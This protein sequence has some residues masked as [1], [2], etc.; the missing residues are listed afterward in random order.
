LTPWKDSSRADRAPTISHG[1]SSISISLP[2]GTQTAGLTGTG[3]KGCYRTAKKIDFTGYNS[4]KFDFGTVA[5][6]GAVMVGCIDKLDVALSGNAAAQTTV[7]A[8]SGGTK[9]M[10]ISALNG[11]YYIAITMC[12]Y[13]NST[14]GTSAN[15][16]KVYL[17]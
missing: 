13:A 1:T 4:L 16:K 6:G 14:S 10:D 2:A 9:A 7:A 5:V 3:Y 17:E 15:V 8:F 11:E 12:V